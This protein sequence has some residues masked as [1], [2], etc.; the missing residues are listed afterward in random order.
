MLRYKLAISVALV[1]LWGIAA[2][3][4]EAKVPVTVNPPQAYVFLDGKA[5]K[6]GRHITLK[7]TPGEHVISVYN[8]GYQGQIRHVDFIPGWNNVQLFT[9]EPSG[10]KV[11]GPYGL[12]QIEGPGHAAVLLNGTAPEYHVGHVDMFNNHIG[13][14]QQLLVPPGTHQ[15]TIT[16]YGNTIWSGPVQVAAGQRV[17]LYVPSGRRRIQVVKKEDKGPR[18]R[19]EAGIASA[20]VSVA[21]VSGTFSAGPSQVQCNGTAELAY[22][23]VDTLHSS[24]R[25]EYGTRSLTSMS[26][27]IPVQP[28][29][30]TTYYFEASGPGGMVKKDAT[31]QVNSMVQSSLELTPAEV[32]YVK[33]GDKVLTQE[34]SELKWTATNANTISVT[35]IGNVAANGQQTVLPDP[36]QV[37]GPVNET[38]TYTLTAGNVC[39]G[40]DNRTAQLRVKGII[41]PYILSVFFPTGY[42]DRSH[43]DTG[44]VASEQAHLMNVADVFA[45][46]AKDTPDAKIVLTGH[47]DPRGTAKYNMTLSKRRVE[48]AKGFLIAHGVPGDKIVLKPMGK[49]QELAA[50][51]VRQLEAE[52]PFKAEQPKKQNARATWLAYNR[53]VDVEIQPADVQTSRFFPHQATDSPILAGTRWPRLRNVIKADQGSTSTVASAAGGRP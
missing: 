3:A 39:D 38:K 4:Q 6:E 29:R 19:F 52:S 27:E 49:T 37:A 35:S 1:T 12:I 42:P 43:P 20:A 10:A 30:T 45:L 9:L 2:L 51:A 24:I 34:P 46:Y 15:L 36:K 11:P 40:S 25:D 48:V 31:V 17:I 22:S 16:R 44:L 13:W 21:P 32:Q 33:V 41:E 47:A 28:K 53:R 18:L 26:G 8:Y 23:S 7:T 50:A 14:F 5:I